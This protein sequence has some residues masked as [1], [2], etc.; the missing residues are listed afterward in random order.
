MIS[1]SLPVPPPFADEGRGRE[2]E[3]KRGRKKS[4]HS[5]TS[6]SADG[7]HKVPSAEMHVKRFKRA[8]EVSFALSSSF[9]SSSSFPSHPAIS[10]PMLLS[11]HHP[12][13]RVNLFH[14]AV[15]GRVPTSL[16]ERALHIV[17]GC[18][19]PR[20]ETSHE[21]DSSLFAYPP[22]SGFLPSC[23]PRDGKR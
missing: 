19:P 18:I 17:T 15:S 10:F 2:K 6:P 8:P 23:A 1:I 4:A 20:F 14:V 9:S 7:D 21:R 5:S 12:H 22:A 3:K 11:R 16:R 13:R